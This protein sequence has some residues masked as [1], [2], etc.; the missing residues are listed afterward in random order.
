VRSITDAGA[1]R[2]VSSSS[3]PVAMIWQLIFAPLAMTAVCVALQ[4][5]HRDTPAATLI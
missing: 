5:S 4:I 3:V 2:D 1:A